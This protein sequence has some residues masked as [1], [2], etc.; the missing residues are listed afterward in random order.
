[1]Q[2]MNAN[3]E[4]D[5]RLNEAL[6]VW[7]EAGEAGQPMDRQE[8][9]RRY[10]D[11][12]DELSSFFAA[13]DDFEQQAEPLLSGE[14]LGN[15]SPTLV[16]APPGIQ[17]RSVGDYEVLTEIA[18]GGMGVVYRARQISLDRIVALKMIRTGELASAEEIRR[19]QGEA[20]AAASLDHPHIVPIYEV[21]E[22]QGLHYF[23]MKLIDGPSLAQHLA[24][25]PLESRDAARLV[26]QAARAVHHAHQRGVL[27]RDLKPANVL[28]ARSTGSLPVQSAG[29]AG[30]LS[31]EPHITD[32]GLARRAPLG[33]DGEQAALTQSHAILGT[34]PYLSPEQAAGQVKQLTTATDVY[35]LAGLLPILWSTRNESPGTV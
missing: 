15:T 5:N 9:Y 13:K 29:Q 19:F 11:L 28:L 25:G 10:P 22:H 26:A 4:R 24:S 6:A 34:A 2:H 17:V 32:F 14:V 8:L 30:S 33:A 31:Y 21:G 18:R 1:M 16:A 27:H 7:Y 20:T 12:A 35:G 23:S 3:E